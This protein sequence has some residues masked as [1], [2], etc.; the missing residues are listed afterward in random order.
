M[1]EDVKHTLGETFRLT[2][3][4]IGIGFIA[5]LGVGLI[6]GLL[7]DDVPGALG[8]SVAIGMGITA[9]ICV[10]AILIPRRR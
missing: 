1:D 10:A 2:W 4:V 9:V 8:R 6:V 5:S 7:N 3:T